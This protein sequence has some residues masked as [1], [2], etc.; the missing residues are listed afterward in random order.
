MAL[1]SE[2]DRVNP[3]EILGKYGTE[4]GTPLPR[5]A[6]KNM[7]KKAY[8][9]ASK[10]AHPDRN[11]GETKAMV[12][13]NVA[14]DKL[15]DPKRRERVDLG[16]DD[17]PPTQPLDLNARK[18]LAQAFMEAVMTDGRV[19]YISMAKRILGTM[20]NSQ[21]ANVKEIQKQIDKLTKRMPLVTF[22]PTDDNP[23]NVWEDQLNSGLSQLK[24]R[25]DGM[26]ETIK[27]IDRAREM[28]VAYKCFVIETPYGGQDAM[29]R[30]LKLWR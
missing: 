22:D 23:V 9:R 20:A 28:I 5:D 19:N 25:Q 13:V 14:Y 15:S 8:R 4:D 24:D 16:L 18:V 30:D 6:D 26:K 27:A 3:Y 10:K 1:Q 21:Y 7:I 17:E 11:G 29:L 12:A 2:G